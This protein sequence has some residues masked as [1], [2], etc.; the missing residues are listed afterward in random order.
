MFWGEAILR[1]DD[2]DLVPKGYSA[3]RLEVV[4]TTATTEPAA[5]KKIKTGNGVPTASESVRK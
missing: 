4:I 3:M 5:M 1:A 2:N